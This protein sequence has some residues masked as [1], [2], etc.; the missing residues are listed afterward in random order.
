MNN[1]YMGLDVEDFIFGEGTTYEENIDNVTDEEMNAFG[2]I[3]CTE[4]PDVACYR[5]AL[6]NEQNHNAI[7]MAMIQ[8]EYN[9]LEST[10]SVM[11]YEGA[12]IDNFLDMVKRN[13]QK[14]WAKV[15][16]VFKKV[17]DQISSIVLSNKA[18]VKK[19]RSAGLKMPAEP[20]G[21]TGYDFD[22]VDMTLHYS[23]VIDIVREIKGASNA[24]AREVYGGEGAK[25]TEDQLR[26]AIVKG[27][28]TIGAEEFDKALKVKLYGAEN[29]TTV[30]PVAFNSLLD[31]LENAAASKKEAKAA[32]K[33][34]EK[35]IKGLLSEV[36]SEKTKAKSDAAVKA[37]KEKATL[38][39]K[40]LNVMSTALSAQTRAIVAMA[41][42]DRKM[43]NYIVRAN[44]TDVKMTKESAVVEELD[45]VLI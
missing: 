5:I 32:H 17:M 39:N 37:A 14:F 2:V 33:E 3:E 31:R 29:T 28:G 11:V 10:G 24:D 26:G 42:Q 22:K 43:A 9:V 12:K 45:V 21:F 30:K 16:G 15:K 1:V 34:A 7:M 40:S 8:R 25:H 44:N 36:N 23:K 4:D 18:F 19:Y 41:A 35:T 27:S 6:E 38:I 13:I 20:K